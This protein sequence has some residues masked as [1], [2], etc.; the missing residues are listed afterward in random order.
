MLGSLREQHMG[1]IPFELILCNN[2]PRFHLE[3]SRFSG[4]G[5]ALY[6]FPDI[7][8]INSNHNWSTDIRFSLATLAKNNTIFFLDDDLILQSKTFVA[9]MFEAFLK[10]TP[11]D[12]LSCW[13]MLWTEWTEDSFTAVSL[14]FK[15][16]SVVELTKSDIV[17]P[18]VCMFDKHILTPNVLK[19]VMP[20]KHRGADDMVFPLA[21]YL[22]H[23][24]QAYYFPSYNMLDFHTQSTEKALNARAGHYKDL[25]ALYKS[26][27]ANGYLPVISR[28][29]ENDDSPEK[30]AIATLPRHTFSW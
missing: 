18:G 26:M 29:A 7:R 20:V 4:I 9:S 28:L 12:I 3:K 15:T 1:Q 11:L 21:A 6:R 30:R 22:E 17:G 14:T 5:R 23:K 8:I 16:S 13:N 2:S 24:S 10:L 27:F 25:H 19:A